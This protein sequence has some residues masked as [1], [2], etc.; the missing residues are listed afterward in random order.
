MSKKTLGALVAY[1]TDSQVAIAMLTHAKVSELSDLYVSVKPETTKFASFYGDSLQNM[2]IL[3]RPNLPLSLL[4]IV[5]SSCFAPGRRLLK[6]WM[7]RPL[8]SAKDIMKRQEGL[9]CLNS[10]P[11]LTSKIR[12]QLKAVGDLEKKLSYIYSLS[13]EKDPDSADARAIIYDERKMKKSLAS[14]SSI[15]VSLG[16]ANDIFESLNAHSLTAEVIQGLK[17]DPEDL[18]TARDVCSKF[19]AIAAGPDGQMQ[20]P[21]GFHVD[22]DEAKN[23]L[24][25]V[26]KKANAYLK[27][28][29]RQIGSEVKYWGSANAIYQLE[30]PERLTKGLSKRY[31]L[32][33]QRKGFKRYTT[34]ETNELRES[35]L[36]LQEAVKS[37]YEGA[38]KAILRDFALHNALWRKLTDRLSI[39]DC[40]LCLERYSYQQDEDWCVPEVLDQ[41][42][43]VISIENGRHPILIE[44]SENGQFIANSIELRDKL[45][46]LTGPNMGGKSTTMRQ[47]GLLVVL[48]QLGCRVPAQAMRLTPIDGLFTRMGARD[49]IFDGESTFFVELSETVQILRHATARSLVLIDELGRGTS[50][51]DGCAIALATIKKLA[52]RSF[53]IFSTHYHEMIDLIKQTEL[54]DRIQV[55]RMAVIEPTATQKLTYLYQLER[56]ECSLSHGFSTALSAGIPKAI[57]D[58]AQAKAKSILAH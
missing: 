18:K 44:M 56:G 3:P 48:A 6:Q 49:G 58:M 47:T 39:L 27:E 40:L 10:S 5:D 17:M 11:E 46:V 38:C 28:Q 42:D 21:A 41:E 2:D 35:Y 53:G 20:I 12:K 16:A 14:I 52:G 15:I 7:S 30:V 1:L 31:I 43:A 51:H 13:V 37:R 19:A 36:E 54:N 29:Q 57:V 23:E 55:F 25:E 32:S 33:S 9:K 50:T 45:L 24:K 8:F 34:D 22:Y 26:E 4:Q